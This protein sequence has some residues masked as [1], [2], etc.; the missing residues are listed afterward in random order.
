MKDFVFGEQLGEGAYSKALA[1][2]CIHPYVLFAQKKD[3]KEYYA[4]KIV[5]KRFIQKVVV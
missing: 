3:T 2:R 5:N 1:F 4:V